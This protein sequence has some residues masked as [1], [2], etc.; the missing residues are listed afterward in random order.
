MGPIPVGVILEEKKT[1]RLRDT[2]RRGSHE[3]KG[4]DWDNVGTRKEISKFA[5]KPPEARRE[6]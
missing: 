4:R 2:Q 5:R 3:D 1:D 6:T